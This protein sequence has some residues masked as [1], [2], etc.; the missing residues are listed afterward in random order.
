L[1]CQTLKKLWQSSTTSQT[2]RE[3][4]SQVCE[5][6]TP[7]HMAQDRNRWQALVNTVMKFRVP[8]KAGNLTTLSIISIWRRTVLHGVRFVELMS[9]IESMDR[10][11]HIVQA[12]TFL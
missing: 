4:S 11:K 12:D 1:R 6:Y 2:L 5:V 7:D 3:G 10:N 9:T 8:W